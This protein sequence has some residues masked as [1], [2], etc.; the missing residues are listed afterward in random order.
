MKQQSI[1]IFLLYI[2]LQLVRVAIFGC[3]SA[4]LSL[5][6]EFLLA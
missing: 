4:A 1:L 2:F 5:C 3:G 6:G